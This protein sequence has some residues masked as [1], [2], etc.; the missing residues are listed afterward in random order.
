MARN[1]NGS[2]EED[3]LLGLEDSEEENGADDEQ[4]LNDEPGGFVEVVFKGNRR[5]VFRN[6][7][8]LDLV[9]GMYVIVE[10]DKGEDLGRVGMSGE[11]IRVKGEKGERKPVLRLANERE[12]SQWK[13][14]RLREEEAFEDFCTRVATRG[15]DMKPVDVEYQ[16]DGCKVIFYFTA[17]QRVDFRE[18]VKELAGVYRT[19][20]ELRQIG[21]RDEAM[22]LGGVGLCG[23]QICCETFLTAFLPITSQMARDQNLSLN[24][25]KLSG[26]C[27]RLKCCLR[28]EHTFYV[29]ARDRFPRLGTRVIL[30]GHEARVNKLDF[31]SERI[32]VRSEVGDER[33]LTLVEYDRARE[34]NGRQRHQSTR[35]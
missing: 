26:L 12:L 1:H 11:E 29:E 18:L 21:V 22:R 15:M 17:D 25:A 34:G 13:Q 6:P 14:L 9:R 4:E 28:F 16:L 8:E 3:E 31:F 7:R 27:G 33:D 19:R 2:A 35:S 32:T 10:A 30:E 20:I 23:R 5:S 24:P